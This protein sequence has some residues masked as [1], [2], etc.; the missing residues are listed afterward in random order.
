MAI[1]Q[2]FPASFRTEWIAGTHAFGTDT[3]KIALYTSSASLGPTTTAYT[4]TGEV[5]GTGYTAGG[6]TLSSYAVSGSG[7]TSFI[8]WADATWAASTITARGAMIYNASKSNKAVLILDFGI[9]RSSNNTTFTVKFPA[10]DAVN[11]IIR[12]TT[13]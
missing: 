8:D 1:V 10:A 7:S 4:A 12:V 6:A 13:T 5:S 3:F 11:A 2:G 9:D